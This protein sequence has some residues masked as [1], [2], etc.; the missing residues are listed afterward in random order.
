MAD[1][2]AFWTWSL[3]TYPRV[4]DL[5]LRLQD[6]YGADINLLLFCAWIGRLGRDELDAAEAA[7]APWRERVLVPLR[8]ARRA[9]RGARIYES[10]KEVELEAERIAQKKIFDALSSPSGGEDALVLYL[11]RIGA[12]ATLK[13]AVIAGFRQG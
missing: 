8:Q 5:A 7:V 10:L 4:K 3:K 11:N 12:P 13:T 6:E 1:A 2:D 9:A